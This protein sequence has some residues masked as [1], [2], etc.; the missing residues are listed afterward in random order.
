MPFSQSSSGKLGLAILLINNT[1][2]SYKEIST[3]SHPGY[4]EY[5]F[6]VVSS[7]LLRISQNWTGQSDHI[8]L[9]AESLGS[10]GIAGYGHFVF[11]TCVRLWP[12]QLRLS[13]SFLEKQSRFTLN[14]FDTWPQSGSLLMNE[15]RSFL[16]FIYSF[17]LYFGNCLV[18]SCELKFSFL[19]I[20]LE[21]VSFTHIRCIEQV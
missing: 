12:P 8:A 2:L 4:V 13:R 10:S 1:R 15:R 20:F 9:Y 7:N 21:F 11:C 6:G 3:S 14:L 17:C 5:L 18:W 19:E 16:P